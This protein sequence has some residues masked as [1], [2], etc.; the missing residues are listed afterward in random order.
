MT[1]LGELSVPDQ[2]LVSEAFEVMGDAVAR[3]N[4]AHGWRAQDAEP[5]NF[6]ELIALAHSELSEALDAHRNNE[7]DLWYE[8]ENVNGISGKTGPSHEFADQSSLVRIIDGAPVLGK[9]CGA[10]SELADTIIRILDMADELKMPVTQA[11]LE[12]HAYNL[13]R[14]YKHG[15]KKF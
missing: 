4:Y 3:N 10:A 12:K 7:P 2:R 15:G 1:Q 11:L 6:G 14:P 5:R 8:H 9:P 13:T